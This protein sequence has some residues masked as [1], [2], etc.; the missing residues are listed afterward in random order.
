[1][2]RFCFAHPATTGFRP[3]PAASENAFGVFHL[4][5]QKEGRFAPVGNQS[6]RPSFRKHFLGAWGRKQ[7]AAISPGPISEAKRMD[8]IELVKG[9]FLQ[10]TFPL[11]HV[12]A[13]P[14]VVEEIPFEEQMTALARHAQGDWGNLDQED[15]AENEHA[16]QAGYRLF[17]VYRSKNDVKFWIITE[18]DRSVTTILLP[19]EY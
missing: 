15:W 12:C 2:T 17:S 19:D 10:V 5:F 1:L 16:L 11:G 4:C 18:A 6:N 9:L 13:T 7:G 3:P 14:G 8:T